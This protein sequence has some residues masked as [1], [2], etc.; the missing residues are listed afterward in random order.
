MDETEKISTAEELTAKYPAL[1]QQ[2]KESAALEATNAENARLKA[3]DE[4]AG[5]ISDGMVM[6]AK[7][8][9]RKITA[10]ALA[11]EA[12]RANGIMAAAALSNMKQDIEESGTSEI[13][14]TANAGFADSGE[15]AEEQET[16]VRNLAEK[17][18]RKRR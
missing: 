6:K 3:I 4:I 12:F 13:V 1:V 15:S 7:Y 10:E 2:I 14:P 17:F 16:K 5:Q 9:E 18:K 11:L 8:G